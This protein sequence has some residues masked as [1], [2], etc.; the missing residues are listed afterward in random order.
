MLHFD[1][2]A[3]QYFGGSA[4]TSDFYQC[5][6][7]DLKMIQVNAEAMV[8]RIGQLTLTFAT[9]T[10]DSPV[11]FWAAAISGVLHSQILFLEAGVIIQNCQPKWDIQKLVF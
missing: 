11:V 5:G 9:P 4:N 6:W 2:S 1:C 3:I 8:Q 10:N 7:R